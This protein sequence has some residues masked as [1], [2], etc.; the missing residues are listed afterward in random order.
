MHESTFNYL[1][2]TDEQIDQMQACREAVAECAKILGAAV[3][4]G[5]DRVRLN[6]AIAPH[7]YLYRDR[8]KVK[9]ATAGLRIAKVGAETTGGSK[10]SKRSPVSGSSAEIRGAASCTS[11]PT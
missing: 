1:K 11:A 4:D 8:I 2:P 3:P 5:P 6:W 9:T 10:P 7:Y